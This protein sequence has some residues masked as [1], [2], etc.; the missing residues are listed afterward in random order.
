MFGQKNSIFVSGSKQIKKNAFSG[1][2]SLSDGYQTQNFQVL[3]QVFQNFWKK[4]IFTSITVFYTQ[5]RL[6]LRC[7]NHKF[8]IFKEKLTTYLKSASNLD[9]EMHFGYI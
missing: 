4:R 8:L 3:L 7:A 9:L 1:L 5:N 2:H 6:Y